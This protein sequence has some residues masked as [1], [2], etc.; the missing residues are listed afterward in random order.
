MR[1]IL[2]VALGLIATFACA[3]GFSS[4]EERMSQA[5][6]HAAGLDKLSPD[7]LKALNAWLAAH[8][9]AATP[10]YVT[11]SGQPVFYPHQSERGEIAAHIVGPFSGWRGQTVFTLD[12]GQKWKQAESG[13]YD[14]G[15]FENPAVTIKPMMMGSWLMYVEPC[16]NQSIR[17]TRVK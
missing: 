12:N 5:D 8:T 17:V 10:T 4:L 14:C 16:R 9:G 3:S 6:F 13:S 2:A 1:F 11:P 15:K 7:E